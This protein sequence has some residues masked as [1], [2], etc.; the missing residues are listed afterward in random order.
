MRGV[1]TPRIDAL[2]QSGMRLPNYNVESDCVPTRSALMTGR[3]PI[4]TGAFQSVPPGR[5]Q[6]LKRTEW[7]RA[8]MATQACYG[9]AHCA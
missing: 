1:A 6:G 8:A 7:T 2:A 9:H 3:P 5:P 4:R